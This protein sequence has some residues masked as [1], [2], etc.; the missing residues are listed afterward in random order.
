MITKLLEKKGGTRKLN[1]DSKA[2]LDFI[3]T[4]KLVDVH[5]KSGAF[6]WNNRRVG[7]RQIASRLDRF[8]ISESILLEGVIVESDILPSGGSD[9]WPISLI[10]TIEGTLRNNPF[11]FE[12]FWLNHLDFTQLVEKR[13][14]EPM[15][16]RGTKMYKLQGKLRYIKNKIKTW[17]IIFFG[18]I[19]KEKAKIEEQLE[20]IHK[21]W[22][23]G[24]SNLETTNK[25]K[26][27]MQQ[28]QLRCQQE[29]TL[30][31]QKS[32]IQWLKEGEH[33]TTFFHRS[34]L[35]YRGANKILSLK[36]E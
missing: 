12:K 28:W 20:Q 16:I 32:R 22:I 3:N 17:N 18:N 4:A 36:S 10:A 9:H 35:D 6:T 2:F 5:L 7:E 34:T 1:K 15:D 33:N 19:F 31:K 29:E 26:N 27:L 13:W 30:R 14:H 23:T 8:L 21:G 11:R 24:D 25:E